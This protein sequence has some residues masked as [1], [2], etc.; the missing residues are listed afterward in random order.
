M[1]GVWMGWSKRRKRGVSAG[2][3]GRGGGMCRK[4]GGGGSGV[5]EEAYGV[6]ARGCKVEVKV[7]VLRD[8]VW[9]GGVKGKGGEIG[10]CEGL[11]RWGG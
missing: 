11:G 6:R 4:K 1:K 10:T 7:C 3:A 5:W 2:E 9:N 8:K